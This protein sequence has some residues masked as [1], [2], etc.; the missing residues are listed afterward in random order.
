MVMS[1][2]KE[3]E[4]WHVTKGIAE[5]A[6]EGNPQ[7]IKA[8]QDSCAGYA[9]RVAEMTNYTTLFFESIVVPPS[10]Q[11]PE[12]NFVASESEIQGD[13]VVD[14]SAPPSSSPPPGS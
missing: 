5:E 7:D 4:I 3:M 10:T 11:E 12:D 8:I 6:D 1:H 13:N 2:H 14:S 9:C